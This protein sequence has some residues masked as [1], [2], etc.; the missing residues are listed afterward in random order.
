MLARVQDQ[1]KRLVFQIRDNAGYR[2]LG[3]NGE[4]KQRCEDRPNKGGV[5]DHAEIDEENRS[6][7]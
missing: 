3:L 5:A 6:S 1:Q 2:V 7:K 4:S